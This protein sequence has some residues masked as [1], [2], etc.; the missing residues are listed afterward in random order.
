ML[1]GRRGQNRLTI[2]AVIMLAVC[3][4]ASIFTLTL[5]PERPWWLSV[6][7]GS[8]SGVLIG[9]PI[10]LWVQLGVDT[11]LGRR[12]KRLPLIAY[13]VVNAVVMTAILIAGHFAAYHLIW[14]NEHD[15]PFLDDPDLPA[16]MFFSVL[17]VTAIS[18]AVELRRLIGPGV[19]GA[20]LA[21]TYRHPQ[22]E[23]RI[24]LMLDLVGSTGIAERL[25]PERFLAFLDR[26]IHALTEPLLAH[27][28]R[29]YRYV[30][31]EVILTWEWRAEAPARALAFA[32][33]AAKAIADATASWQRDFGVVPRMR[34]ALHGGPVVAGEIG[35]VKREITFLGDTLNTAARIAQESRRHEALVVA[36]AE[37]VDGVTL[38]GG[39]ASHPLGPVQLRGKA[40]PI[41]LVCLALRAIDAHAP[42]S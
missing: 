37:V 23:R 7:I 18:V 9:T 42:A 35:D 33:E 25:G 15:R 29:I 1:L 19:F 21:G 26:W 3:A 30:G 2:I 13:L 14:P 17:L 6:A 8:A 10:V 39:L 5:Y 20:V 38:P 22:A 40:E 11:P 4:A 32:I 36:S 31:D 28:G 41:E 24:F 27:D 34:L 12:L 16:S